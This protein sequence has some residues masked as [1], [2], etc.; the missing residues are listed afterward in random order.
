MAPF[1][2]LTDVIGYLPLIYHV[3]PPFL[4][5]GISLSNKDIIIQ[6]KKLLESPFQL[7]FFVCVCV[8]LCVQGVDCC[9]SCLFSS[10]T[11]GN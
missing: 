11:S 7:P 3:L 4:S 1:C 6:H 9:G 10:H 8:L 2:A 5:Y